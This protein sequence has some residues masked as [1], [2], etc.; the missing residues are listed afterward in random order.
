[1]GDGALA[2]RSSVA[3]GGSHQQAGRLGG[4]PVQ[5]VADVV[6]V[7]VGE[8]AVQ[9]AAEFVDSGYGRRCTAP[10]CG[11]G[12]ATSGR[13]GAS[14]R[15]R[16]LTRAKQAAEAFM[17]TVEAAKRRGTFIDPAAGRMI[18]GEFA[19]TWLRTRTY[20]KLTMES[21]E[22]RVRKHIL[23]FFGSRPLSS[24][25]PSA[26][27]EWDGLGPHERFGVGVP[28]ALGHVGVGGVSRMFGGWERNPATGTRVGGG[29]DTREVNTR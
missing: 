22:L 10:G 21:L 7:G 15:S 13:T 23:P 5:D 19:E 17:A 16:F 6:G 26:V 25:K 18:F 4:V 1:V 8:S 3:T 2:G 14:V 27:A 9:S 24:I 20:D 12:F 11:T 29:S 28:V